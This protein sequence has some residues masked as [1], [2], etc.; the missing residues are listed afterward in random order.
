M[1]LRA[2]KLSI[3][4]QAD[5]NNG[6][7]F[8]VS[9]IKFFRKGLA[10]KFKDTLGQ[11]TTYQNQLEKMQQFLMVHQ[12]GIDTEKLNLNSG[13]LYEDYIT[14]DRGVFG[15]RILDIAL[16][17]DMNGEKIIIHRI[18]KLSSKNKIH[19]SNSAITELN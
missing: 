15:E 18:S 13:V 3:D 19:I 16:A 14:G 11:D 6:R 5:V 8:T 12:D 17:I 4:V 7:A 2:V 9:I 1:E 10:E